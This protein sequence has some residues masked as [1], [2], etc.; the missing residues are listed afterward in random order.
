MKR[1]IA[2]TIVAVE[3][4]RERERESIQFNRENLSIY[5]LYL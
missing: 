1:T 3:R 2:R 5:M 4:E